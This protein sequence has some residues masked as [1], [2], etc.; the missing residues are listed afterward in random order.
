MSH[1]TMMV[2]RP[3]VAAA[4]ARLLATVV[5][6]SLGWVEVIVTVRMGRSMAEK[7]MLA[8]SVLA[9]FCIARV[10]SLFF[11]PGMAYLPAFIVGMRPTTGMPRVSSASS[12][13]RI[14]VFS[15]SMRTMPAMATNRPARKA[16][17]V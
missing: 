13:S 7:R 6:P 8:S 16:T 1:S 4:M 9:A 11:L 5:L 14:L 3:L 12:A 2:R 17:A 15:M 10:A